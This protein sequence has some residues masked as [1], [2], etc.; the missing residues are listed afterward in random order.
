MKAA[1]TKLSSKPE[2]FSRQWFP[3]NKKLPPQTKRRTSKFS[4]VKEE[5]GSNSED[6]K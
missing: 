4:Q 3:G 5:K 6:K 1:L 2:E